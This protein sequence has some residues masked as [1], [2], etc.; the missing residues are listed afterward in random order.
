MIKLASNIE[1]LQTQNLESNQF[2]KRL[3]RSVTEIKAED[4]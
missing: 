1:S 4:A 2:A 3:S